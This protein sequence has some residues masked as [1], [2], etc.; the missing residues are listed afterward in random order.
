MPVLKVI[1]THFS[2]LFLNRAENATIFH[3]PL[4]EESS[5]QP[6]APADATGLSTG[7]F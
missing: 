3:L 2:T 1:C 6:P 7:V 4:L 5:L